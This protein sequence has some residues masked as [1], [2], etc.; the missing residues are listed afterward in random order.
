MSGT[1]V[2]KGLWHVFLKFVGTRALIIVIGIVCFAIFPKRGFVYEKKSTHDIV[3]LKNVW[4]KFDSY[5][6]QKLAREGYPK[7][8]FTD[9]EQQTWGFMPLYPIC[10][11]LISRLFGISLFF[12]GI[13]ISNICALFALFVIYKLCHEKFNTG[14]ETVN[15][16]LICAGS[17]Y[18]SIV[19]TEGLFLLFTALVF[20]L[21][22]KK[23]YGLALIIAGLATVTRLQGCLLFAIPVIEIILN[24]KKNYLR[25]ALIFLLSII[26]LVLFLLYLNKTCGD[27][28][29]FLKIQHAWGSSSLFPLQGFVNLLNGDRFG[30]SLINSLFWVMILGIVISCF[31]KLP[32]SYLVFTLAYF[33]LST[34]NEIVYGTTR[35]MLGVLPVF[36]AVS[37]SPGYV[38]QAFIFINIL[39]LA[40]AITAFVT[41]TATFI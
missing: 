29:A 24:H 12:S 17:F 38:K 6:Y 18:L 27:A 26:P 20:Y 41:N 40:L 15:M 39:F 25:Y 4:D 30:A 36:I 19:Y 11:N 10:I 8:Q 9:A 7:R 32:L 5:W 34:S 16:I 22:H 31:R 3:N 21:S 28:F 33:L 23:N 13:F 14:T 2:K 37:L 35:Y 1:L